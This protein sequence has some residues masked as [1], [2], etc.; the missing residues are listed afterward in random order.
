MTLARRGLCQRLALALA[1]AAVAPARA[2]RE[3]PPRRFDLHGLAQ[4]TLPERFRFI[5]LDTRHR[6]LPP[7]AQLER[8]DGQG[9]L[10]FQFEADNR[11][12][13]GG[14][15]LDP[16]L[17]NLV[18]FDP[19]QP[20][21]APERGFRI[22]RYFSPT[23]SSI[24]LTDARWTQHADARGRVWRVLA[25]ND[26]F[27]SDAAPRWA[28]T[29]WD[30]ALA[31]R[32]ELFVWRSWMSREQALAL[33]ATTLDSLQPQPAREAFFR[34][35]G[36]TEQRLVALRQQHVA[37]FFAALAPLGVPPAA[38]GAITLG[39]DAAAWQDDDGQA[40]RALRVLARIELGTAVPRSP[41]GRP[42]LSR[43]AQAADLPGW[44]PE[45]L[46]WHAA[47]GSWRKTGMPHQRGPDDWP[48]QPI[49]AAV[50]RRLPQTAPEREGGFLIASFHAYQPPVLDDV[51]ELPGFL[52]DAERWR[53]ALI[54]RRLL[55]AASAVRL[56]PATR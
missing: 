46:Y 22:E 43:P 37:G 31:V 53:V 42:M 19:R 33:L 34:R 41:T 32:A 1:G 40:L 8:H 44:T 17:L 49:E 54:D 38:P 27:G 56:A 23:G 21:A 11:N 48:L 14:H 6:S 10:V 5:G 39:I 50:A 2:W 52:A 15:A 26:H 3:R 7:A 13:W 36:S 20:G 30:P 18:L 55:S 9:G 25:M 29:A 45:L 35:T 47:S 16:L 24:A 28:V 12:S 51:S 4:V